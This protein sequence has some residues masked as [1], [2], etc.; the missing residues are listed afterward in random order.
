MIHPNEET[1][2]HLS[3]NWDSEESIRLSDAFFDSIAMQ[4]KL[5]DYVRYMEGMSGK[6]Y[7]YLINN[8]VGATPNARYLEV[9]SWKGSTACSAMMGNKCRV[10]CID[11][12]AETIQG[13]HARGDFLKNTANVVDQNIDFTFLEKDFRDVDYSSLGKFNIYMYDGAHGEQDQYDGL[14]LVDVALE[15]IYTLI[16]DDWN[17]VD[18]QNGT[19]SA[20]E[21][22]GHTVISRIDVI[23]RRDG[24]HP[25]IHGPGSDWHNGYFIAVVKR[26]NNV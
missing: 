1:S 3:G 10:V 4:H 24:I 22:L 21:K 14:A 26:N 5:P 9:G 25:Q 16:V 12:W 19:L 17:G 23:T 8:L 13:V 18:S 7:R 15:D 6:K 20:L 2:I 11:N